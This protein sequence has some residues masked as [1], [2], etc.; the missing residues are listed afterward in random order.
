MNVICGRRQLAGSFSRGQSKGAAVL[1]LLIGAAMLLVA[2][3]AAIYGFDASP[4]GLSGRQ[5]MAATEA[6]ARGAAHRLP[7]VE[8]ARSTARQL[9]QANVATPAVNPSDVSCTVDI[10]GPDTTTPSSPPF[11]KVAP[12]SR[13]IQIKASARSISSRYIP[14]PHWAKT[15]QAEQKILWGPAHSAPVDPIYIRVSERLRLHKQY[16]LPF[17]SP[18]RSRTETG[19]AWLQLPGEQTGDEQLLVQKL[20]GESSV[21]FAPERLYATVGDTVAARVPGEPEKWF[22]AMTGTAETPGRLFRASQP[23]YADQT[24]AA[25]SSHHP[26]L[27]LVPVVEAADDGLQVRELSAVWLENIEVHD[28]AISAIVVR[29]IRH[30]CSSGSV[31][32]DAPGGTLYAQQPLK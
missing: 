13:I 9:L 23:P 8:Q 11:D 21:L 20:A 1:M 22:A 29:P 18:N 7:D 4:V 6:A 15:V 19:F 16:R 17:I 24:I 27:L 30:T 28:G 5:M 3:G 25:H 32:T 31:E 14:L 10:Y 12:A 2:L 26:R